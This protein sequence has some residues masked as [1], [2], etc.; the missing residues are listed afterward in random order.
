MNETTKSIKLP[1]QQKAQPVGKLPHSIEKL[2]ED[3]MLQAQPPAMRQ[4]KI[5]TKL[6]PPIKNSAQDQAGQV[7]FP[8]QVDPSKFQIDSAVSQSIRNKIKAKA[9][10]IAELQAQKLQQADYEARTRGIE[11]KKIP[12]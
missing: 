11:K 5:N 8:E 7:M 3:H 6:M 2:Q 10:L 1:I 12:I 9:K 4:K